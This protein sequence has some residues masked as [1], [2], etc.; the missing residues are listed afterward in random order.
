MRRRRAALALLFL[1]PLLPVTAAVATPVAA[2]AQASGPGLAKGDRELL[3][4]ALAERRSQVSLLVAANPGANPQVAERARGMGA[5]VTYRDDDVSYLRLRVS[6]QDAFAIASSD[7]IA[8][9]AVDRVIEPDEPE[10]EPPA[11]PAV[12]DGSYAIGQPI[13]A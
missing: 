12:V 2:A 5:T 1:L 7:G 9:A 8:A 3:A 6:P 11:E 10:L 4:E 13:T